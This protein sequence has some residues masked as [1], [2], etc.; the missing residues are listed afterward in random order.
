MRLPAIANRPDN[1]TAVLHP[2]SSHAPR[3][4]SQRELVTQSLIR[5]PDQPGPKGRP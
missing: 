3:R 1:H 4:I 2:V 5:C